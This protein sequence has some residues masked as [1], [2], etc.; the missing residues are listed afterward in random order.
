[1]K[2]WIMNHYAGHMRTDKG[3]RH[4]WFSKYLNLSGHSPVVFCAIGKNVQKELLTVQNA[5]EINTPFVNVSVS[6]TRNGGLSKILNMASFYFRVKKAAKQYAKAD[7][8]PDVILASSVH[9]LT[10]VA[11]LKIA[12]R[13]KVK[14]ICEVRDLWPE[15]ILS[16]SKKIKKNSLIAKMMYAGE[17]WIYKKADALIFT[18]EGCPDYIREHKWDKEQ[19]GPIDLNKAYY[20]NNG[21]D[22][23]AFDQN[24]KDFR[25]DD[26]DMDDPDTIKVVYAGAIRHVNNLGLIVDAAKLIKN[27][28]VR[29]VIF[30]SGDQLEP[31]KKRLVDENITNVVFK[32]RIN[33]QYIP[34][35]VTRADINLAHWRMNPL[36]RVG[37]SCNKTFDY[38]AAGKPM[39][40]TV[41]PGYSIVEKHNCGVLT[42]GFTAQDVANGIEKILSMSEEEIKRMNEN[43]REAAK[44]YDFKVLTQTLLD[45]IDK[46]NSES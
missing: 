41:R 28:K 2:I 21:V 35:V 32:G 14:C 39:F 33:K 26:P 37:E 16:Y 19:G 5:E 43:A 34:S 22:L 20:I 25:F 11:G 38:L 13:F 36:L 10:L 4:Y 30:G 45:I 7:G 44:V 1:M 18:Q 42:E 46:V 29:F 24:V 27:P 31:L 9:P 6:G 3:G 17:K 23:D 12:K 40:Y 8:K 15:A